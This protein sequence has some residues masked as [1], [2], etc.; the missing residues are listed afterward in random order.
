MALHEL[1]TNAVKYGALS[2][3]TGKVQI[4][5]I[6]E[7]KGRDFQ[8]RWS[9]SGGPLVVVP[10]RR[11]FG[12]RLIEQGLSQDLAAQVR[13]EFEEEGVVCTIKAPIDE[14]RA[15]LGFRKTTHDRL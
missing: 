9:E 2:N 14:V 13:L 1:A 3:D 11:G 7:D 5:W 15:G 12:S 8:F 4:S 6:V 10:R